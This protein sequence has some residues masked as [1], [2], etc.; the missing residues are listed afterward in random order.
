MGY[1]FGQYLGPND[2]KDPRPLE[3]T[4]FVGWWTGLGSPQLYWADYESFYAQNMGPTTHTFIHTNI[5]MF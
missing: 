1:C 5:Y 4:M 2:D 3:I